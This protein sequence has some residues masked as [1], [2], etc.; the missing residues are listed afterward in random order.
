[1]SLFSSGWYLLYTKP[2][3][4]KKV[5]ISLTEK[6]ITHYLPLERQLK[7]WKDKKAIVE[8][9]LFPSY[10]F[11]DIT[12]S[13]EYIAG[14]ETDGVVGYVKF[15]KSVAKVDK[16]VV[17]NLKIVTDS[18]NGIEVTS[19]ALVKGR[20]MMVVEGSLAGLDCEVVEHKG[21]EKILVR[22]NLLNRNVL[23]TL[24]QSVLLP[25]QAVLI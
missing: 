25:K 10:V 15:G 7:K 3:C 22:V 6:R 21:K 14:L 12:G 23:M 1:M 19:E 24:N 17:N 8:T 13:K 20:K 16:R 4:E 18:F 11:V 2:R 5:S 9:P